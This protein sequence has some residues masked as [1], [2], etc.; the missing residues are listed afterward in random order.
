MTASVI[1]QAPVAF[2]VL[3]DSGKDEVAAGK[4]I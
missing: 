1:N 2:I 3:T 4:S